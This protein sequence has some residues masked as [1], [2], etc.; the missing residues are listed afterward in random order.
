MALVNWNKFVPKADRP[1][2]TQ[3]PQLVDWNKWNTRKNLKSG[4]WGS[5]GPGNPV[6]PTPATPP[7]GGG[8]ST[9]PDTTAN[10]PN[11]GLDATYWNN[12]LG[13]QGSTNNQ[14]NALTTQ[15][16]QNQVALQSA[17]DNLE[18][19]RPYDQLAEMY[20]ANR[21]GGLYSSVYAQNQGLLG[22]K[23]AGQESGLKTDSAN[24]LTNL[25][26]QIAGLQDA[27]PFYNEGQRL[28]S[29]GRATTALASDP[30]AVVANMTVSPN[31]SFSNAGTPASTVTRGPGTTGSTTGPSIASQ[32]GKGTDWYKAAT[33][34]IAKAGR[35]AV[36]V[37]NPYSKLAA[38][39]AKNQL[40]KG[41]L[42]NYN[43]FF[44]TLPPSS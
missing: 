26:I 6:L 2:Y 18:A 9:A 17:L 14:V 40:R 32:F 34:A 38:K 36:P 24:T 13:N 41:P 4:R 15:G 43:K 23:Y 19:Q 7:T 3:A 1:P 11:A 28:D 39:A 44:P 16:A 21:S 25:A 10:D 33:Q 30:A 27:V 8:G 35:V 29:L 20:G 12:V 37:A 42:V 5:P 31:G 22:E